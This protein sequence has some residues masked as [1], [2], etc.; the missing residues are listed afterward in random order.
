MKRNKKNYHNSTFSQIKGLK[1]FNMSDILFIRDYVMISKDFFKKLDDIMK[2]SN[3]F[4]ED[5]AN[6]MLKIIEDVFVQIAQDYLLTQREVEHIVDRLGE[7]L[8]GGDLKDM[9]A[10]QD[11]TQYA[12]TL[13]VPL[14]EQELQHRQR[15]SLPDIAQMQ[16]GLK[17]ALEEISDSDNIKA[18]DQMT[19]CS[20]KL[21][22]NSKD[23]T[24]ITGWMS[25]VSFLQI[26]TMQ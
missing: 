4:I 16:K 22:M 21:R 20:T 11:K 13:L 2:E 24:T 1:N 7:D 17:L 14:I 23:T 6:A 8:T 12:N 19:A 3:N 18:A 5:D 15:I 25:F 26:F 10:C 9:Y